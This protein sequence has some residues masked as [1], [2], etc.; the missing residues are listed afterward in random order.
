MLLVLLLQLLLAT[1]TPST[2]TRLG[3]GPLEK[4]IPPCIL[5][6][7]VVACGLV[8]F[9]QVAVDVSRVIRKTQLNIHGRHAFGQNHIEQLGGVDMVSEQV[10][11]HGGQHV[12]ALVFTAA[13]GGAAGV[14]AAANGGGAAAAGG[15]GL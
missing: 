13:A 4:A 14:G 10:A 7:A 12:G 2:S 9:P 6:H 8:A 11:D 3:N 5:V 15:R 1:T